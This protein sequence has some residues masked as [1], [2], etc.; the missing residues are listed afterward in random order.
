[1]VWIIRI[2]KIIAALS[3][4][5]ILWSLSQ[6]NFAQMGWGII[7]LAASYVVYLAPLWI[8]RLLDIQAS[9]MLKFLTLRICSTLSKEIEIREC[10]E[11]H[12]IESYTLGVT[13]WHPVSFW[14]EIV[15]KTGLTLSMVKLVYAIKYN[16][17]PIQVAIWGENG[18]IASNA[19]QIEPLIVKG[20]DNKF[21]KPEFNPFLSP[22]WVPPSNENWGILGT[23]TFKTIYGNISKKFSFENIEIADKQKWEKVRSQVNEY[24]RTIEKQ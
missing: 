3:G 2:S 13:D 6:T 7:G 14:L 17:I 18:K 8:S 15:N 20:K 24:R 9:K 5:F 12:N 16:N 21:I 11:R 23:I 19:T 1:M 22:Y 4:L 10:K